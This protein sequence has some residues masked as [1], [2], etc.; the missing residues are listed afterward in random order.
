MMYRTVAVMAEITPPPKIAMTIVSANPPALIAFTIWLA[1]DALMPKDPATQAGLVSTPH[2][3]G[4][5]SRN[6]LSASAGVAQSSTSRGLVFS[7]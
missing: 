4:A 1:A 3:N 5:L 6:L 2:S 7:R